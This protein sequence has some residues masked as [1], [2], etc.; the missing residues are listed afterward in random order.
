MSIVLTI[1]TLWS[2]GLLVAS[3]LLLRSDLSALAARRWAP[4]M[5]V[6]VALLA[7][8]VPHLLLPVGAVYDIESYGI[9]GD[10]VLAREDV[11]TSP[12]AIKRYPYLPLQMYWSALARWLSLVSGVSF[13]R[14]VRLLPIAA[15]AGLAWLIYAGVFKL[16][17]SRQAGFLGGL[18]YACSPISVI[19]SAYHGQFDSVPALFVLLAWTVWHS[20]KAESRSDKTERR[21]LLA[22]AFW[23]GMGILIK[24]WP[25]LLLPVMLFQ[26]QGWRKRLLYLTTVGAVSIVAVLF[27]LVVFSAD[28][29]PLVS[30]VLG[31][32]HGISSWGYTYLVRL[33]AM[34]VPS[35]RGVFF[36]L[37]DYSR[38]I[39][40]ALLTIAFLV[41][42]RHEP[43]HQ[44]F[45]TIL[46][47][48]F[49]C[50][51]AFAIQ[52]LVWI[53]PFALLAREHKWLVRYTLGALAYMLL[54]YMT[55][56]LDMRITWLLPW[57]DANWYL[58]IPAG[59][60]LWLVAIGWAWERLT[61]RAHPS[62]G[63]P[64]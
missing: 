63:W 51:H 53:V 4:W 55:L 38:Y 59:L 33:A 3:L 64:S 44:G 39:T 13:L 28:L 10:L 32:N 36:W 22:S 2:L 15:D 1:T 14:I 27:Y 48:F 61:A 5:I 30:R 25:V 58:I 21:R 49:A 17:G 26:V 62:R 20:D 57:P 7:R 31:Y 12:L 23:M 6:G 54:A 37:I 8:I 24:G 11:Y 19:V 35:F 60:P 47:T 42:A 9:V 41:R 50:T 52:Y 43:A 46:A 34:H 45:V 56:I 18:L 40:L 29:V 16:T